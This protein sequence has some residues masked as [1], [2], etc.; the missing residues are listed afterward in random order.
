LALAADRTNQL[1]VQNGT[2]L[3]IVFAEVIFSTNLNGRQAQSFTP[4]YLDEPISSTNPL[5]SL[6][7]AQLEMTNLNQKY[8]Y[9]R[10]RF[11]FR[12][13]STVFSF[14]PYKTEANNSFIQQVRF[15]VRRTDGRYL[16]VQIEEQKPFTN[17]ADDDVDTF[18]DD[19]NAD[20]RQRADDADADTTHDNNVSAKFGGGRNE[21]GYIKLINETDDLDAIHCTVLNWR[22]GER[23]VARRGKPTLIP[24]LPSVGFSVTAFSPRHDAYSEAFQLRVPFEVRIT[25]ADGRYKVVPDPLERQ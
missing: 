24:Q 3:Q 5:P 1:I 19:P 12:S 18:D 22:H 8:R 11:R 9:A 16:Q 13:L 21:S 6:Q 10:F 4:Q 17:V 25:G 15:A 20:K 7:Q 2:P 14:G 23:F